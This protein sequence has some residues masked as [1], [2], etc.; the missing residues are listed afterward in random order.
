MLLDLGFGSDSVS[1]S[2]GS[3][4]VRVEILSLGFLSGLVCVVIAITVSVTGT[5]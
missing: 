4:R 3:V 2:L 5:N 1:I